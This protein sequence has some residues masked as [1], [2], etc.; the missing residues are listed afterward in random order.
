MYGIAITKQT[1]NNACLR[2]GKHHE[3]VISKGNNNI[4]FS[5]FPSTART[6]ERRRS[7][8]HDRPFC[9]SLCRQHIACEY[10]GDT[11]PCP[12]NYVYLSRQS[13]SNH[14]IFESIDMPNHDFIHNA[15][16]AG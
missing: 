6:M 5:F 7:V 1:P 13:V 14:R 4:D 3:A 15:G 10:F 2:R 16:T 9:E 8:E 12:N 11:S